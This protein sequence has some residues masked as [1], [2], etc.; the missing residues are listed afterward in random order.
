VRSGPGSAKTI[1]LFHIISAR[2]SKQ[3]L[4]VRT[5]LKGY[6]EL[7]SYFLFLQEQIKDIIFNVSMKCFTR[8]LLPKFGHG[9]ST[10]RMCLK[11]TEHKESHSCTQV[12]TCFFRYFL[13]HDNVN[14]YPNK[15]AMEPLCAVLEMICERLAIS[16]S[17]STALGSSST[18]FALASL[19]RFAFSS[20]FSAVCLALSAITW[21]SFF[22]S[23]SSAMSNFLRISIGSGLSETNSQKLRS[24]TSI[25]YTFRALL[26]P[27]SSYALFCLLRIPAKTRLGYS[28]DAQQT[29]KHGF[30]PRLG[31]LWPVSCARAARIISFSSWHPMGVFHE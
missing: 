23:T 3:P 9:L 13:I 31:G 20:F 5:F 14:H 26:P 2:P 15:K 30:L 21:L 12:G 1:L 22:F 6:M 28:D 18:A 24:D 4:M 11:Y 25:H 8:H 17:Y 27:S 29:K 19:A 7:G 16:S 10:V